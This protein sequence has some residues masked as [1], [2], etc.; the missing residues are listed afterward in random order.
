MIKCN[1]WVAGRSDMDQFCIRN[2]A[3]GLNCPKY[4]PSLDPVDRANDEEL[5]AANMGGAVGVA[6]RERG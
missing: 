5:R 2:G 1:C 6:L 3:H 4:Q